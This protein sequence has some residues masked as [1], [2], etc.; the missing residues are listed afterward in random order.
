MIDRNVSGEID[1]CPWLSMQFVNVTTLHHLS[2]SDVRDPER[3]AGYI[4][5]ET[6]S[7]DAS[8]MSQ[9]PCGP[10]SVC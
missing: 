10:E 9:K 7:Q 2:K 3:I 6:G 1:R 5:K 4:E 8:G